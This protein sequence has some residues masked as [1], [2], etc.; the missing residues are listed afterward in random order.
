MCRT[1]NSTSKGS[2][3]IRRQISPKAKGADGE[4]IPRVAAQIQADASND[5]VIWMNVV[6][7]MR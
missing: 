3:C 4:L 7:G 1:V 5:G 2:I 6:S